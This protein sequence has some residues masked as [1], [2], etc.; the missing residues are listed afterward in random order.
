[1]RINVLYIG[2][3]SEAET[4]FKAP[5]VPK[6]DDGNLGSYAARGGWYHGATPAAAV[7][8]TCARI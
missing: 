2:R 4:L 3:D 8:A 5:P 6:S 7:S 1:M